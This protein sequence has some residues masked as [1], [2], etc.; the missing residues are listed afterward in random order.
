[1]HIGLG[2][3]PAQANCRRTEN[4]KLASEQGGL[5]RARSLSD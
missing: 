3:S 1:M 5:H 2:L 4:A